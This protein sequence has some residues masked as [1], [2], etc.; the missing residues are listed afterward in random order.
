MQVGIPNSRNRA[1]KRII[2]SGSSS[3][4]GHPY[5][6]ATSEAPVLGFTLSH[7]PWPPDTRPR[8]AHCRMFAVGSNT[9]FEPAR[10]CRMGHHEPSPPGFP[11]CVRR[12]SSGLSGRKLRCRKTRTCYAEGPARRRGEADAGLQTA[13]GAGRAEPGLPNRAGDRGEGGLVSDP[14]SIRG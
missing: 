3:R 6:G 12:D 4:E 13:P 9:T 7:S 8:I 5:F 11:Q 10:Y 1:I 14:P 2:R